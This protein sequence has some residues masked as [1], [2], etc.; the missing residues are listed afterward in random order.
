MHP[1]DAEGIANGVDW[2]LGAVWSGSALLA[3]TYLSEN[4]GSS[5]FQYTDSPIFSK[6]GHKNSQ[7]WKD[8]EIWTT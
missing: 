7:I 2:A 8:T 5:Q 6:Q 4:L 1:K 3:Q